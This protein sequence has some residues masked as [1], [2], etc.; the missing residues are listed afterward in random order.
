MLLLNLLCSFINLI[1]SIV[2]KYIFFNFLV[3][4]LTKPGRYHYHPWKLTKSNLNCTNMHL[5]LSKKKA[6]QNKKIIFFDLVEYLWN[7]LAYVWIDYNWRSVGVF[8]WQ[9]LCFTFC[10]SNTCFLIL[11]YNLN[12]WYNV[13]F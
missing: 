1:V 12:T 5:Y 7:W 13:V 3:T 8:N 6:F 9:Y 11:S 4:L 2:L 10:T